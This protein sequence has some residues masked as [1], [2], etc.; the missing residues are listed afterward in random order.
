MTVALDDDKV[1]ADKD[2]VATS[3]LVQTWMGQ[4]HDGKTKRGSTLYDDWQGPTY[5]SDLGSYV[6]PVS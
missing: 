5:R 4:K 1:E 2:E 6:K 3:V